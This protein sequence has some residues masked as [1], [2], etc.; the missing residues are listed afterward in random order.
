MTSPFRC[1][2]SKSI[3]VW[4][5]Q[6]NLLLSNGRL[7]SYLSI[8][9]DLCIKWHEKI[10]LIIGSG[11]KPSNNRKGKVISEFETKCA[12]TKIPKYRHFHMIS[13][14]S[15][16]NTREKQPERR[17]FQ[18]LTQKHMH[19]RST[20]LRMKK[21]I[22]IRIKFITAKCIETDREGIHSYWVRTQRTASNL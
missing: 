14:C 21:R 5:F 3:L 7:C 13:N 19:W 15:K 20:M 6:C 18:S 8:V 4:F 11:T 12:Y 2:R 22:L 9:D 10:K 1:L 17:R 16:S